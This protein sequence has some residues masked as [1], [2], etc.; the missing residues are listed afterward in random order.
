[1]IFLSA[2]GYTKDKRTLLAFNPNEQHEDFDLDGGWEN[3]S[4]KI[5]EYLVSSFDLEPVEEN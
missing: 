3:F 1:M 5:F 2:L 4:I